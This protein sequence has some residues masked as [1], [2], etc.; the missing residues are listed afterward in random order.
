ML[1][2]PQDVVAVD[3][4]PPSVAAREWLTVGRAR[5]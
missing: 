5:A 3:L 1:E 2:R 4:H